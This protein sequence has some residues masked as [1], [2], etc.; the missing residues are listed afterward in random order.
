MILVGFSL[1]RTERKRRTPPVITESYLEVQLRQYLDRYEASEQRCRE[2]LYR[3]V[4]ASISVH[5]GELSEHRSLVEAVVS[6]QVASGRL[7]DARFAS[8]WVESLRRRGASR[9]KIRF[10]LRQKG[11]SSSVVDSVLSAGDADA[12]RAAAVAYAKRRRLGPYARVIATEFKEK[13]RELAAM[14]RAGF[15]YSLASEVLGEELSEESLYE[16]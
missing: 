6:A 10:S 7:D 5:G 12:E 15:G 8:E 4:R 1:S 3:R 16:K 2:V 13:R 9:L 11:V 14:A